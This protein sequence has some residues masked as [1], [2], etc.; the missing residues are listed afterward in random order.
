MHPPVGSVTAVAYSPQ[1]VGKEASRIVSGDSDYTVRLWDADS[2][3]GEQLGGPLR[4]HQHG[5]MSVAFSPGAGC[6]VSG[7]GDGTVRIWAN[8]PTKAPQDALRDKLA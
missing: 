3:A 1:V 7:S 5:V 6:I 8:P 4:G 2:P